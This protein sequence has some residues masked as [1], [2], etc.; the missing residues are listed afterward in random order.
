MVAVELGMVCCKEPFACGS[1]T[2]FAMVGNYGWRRIA[3]SRER[4]AEVDI[5]NVLHSNWLVIHDQI[6][7][8]CSYR[9][10][11][12]HKQSEGLP[13]S[14]EHTSELQSPCNLVCR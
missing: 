11:L 14:E 2:R 5:S 6:H 12:H 9:R 8:T 7:K 3:P 1:A 4:C 13:R 10:L